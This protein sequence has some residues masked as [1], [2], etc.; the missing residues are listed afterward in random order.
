MKKYLFFTL[1]AL[2]SLACA[3]LT[4]GSPTQPAPTPFSATVPD[5]V[6]TA[7]TS[8]ITR[9]EDVELYCPSDIPEASTAYNQALDF[10][11]A[12]D[13]ESAMQSYREAIRLD[14]EYCD[15]MDNLALLLKQAGNYEEAVTLYQQSLAVYPDGYVAHLGLGNA[16]VQLN[17][18][19]NAIA[20]FETLVKLFPDDPEGYYGLGSVYF[21][22]G[23][24]QIS[25]TQFQ[26]AE[27]IYKALNSDYIV[28][29]QLYI[30]YNYT[31]LEDYE[32]GRNYLELAYPYFQESA[33]TNYMLGYCYYYGET[34]RNEP[35]AKMYLTRARDLGM[36]LEPEL[37]T[38]VNQP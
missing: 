3:T 21:D 25:L 4:G 6:P 36:E 28:D 32:T 20:E 35:L 23:E 24:Y 34:I 30:G 37:E 17:E 11:N 18:Y 22:L 26:Q 5:V 27:E 19:D 31:M 7:T 14:P 16:Y 12:G 33:Y 29:A 9:R 8:G 2:G 15:A 38:F 10:E 13:S 1:F